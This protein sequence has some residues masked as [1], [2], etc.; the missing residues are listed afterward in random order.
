M[1]KHVGVEE[2][3][4]SLFVGCDYSHDV[5]INVTHIKFPNTLKYHKKA[6]KAAPGSQFEDL[7]HESTRC[8]LYL[9][10][11]VFDSLVKGVKGKDI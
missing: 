6:L 10:W 5:M 11:H 4:F 3:C 9:I 1:Q 2:N 7:K 8:S